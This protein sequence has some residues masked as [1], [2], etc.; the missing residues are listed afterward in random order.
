MKNQ[1]DFNG[2]KLKI[3]GNV[4]RKK[5][6]KCHITYLKKI[7]LS[8]HNILKKSQG[9]KNLSKTLKNSRRFMKIQ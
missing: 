1:T 7:T 3:V 8:Y 9:C 2:L 4:A 5:L 6:K